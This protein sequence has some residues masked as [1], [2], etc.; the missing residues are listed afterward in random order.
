MLALSLRDQ[1]THLHVLADLGDDGGAGF[2]D[3]FAGRQLGVLQRFG[4]GGAGGQC[5]LGDGIGE[6]EEVVVL[7]HEVGLGI[8]LDQHGLAA[9]LRHHDAAFGGD[10][11]GLLVGLGQAGLAQP[12]GGGVDVAVVLGERLLA[13]HHAGAGALAQF[14]DQGSRNFSHGGYLGIL[15][16][17]WERRQSRLRHPPESHRD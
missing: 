7:G 5:G 13:L 14:L 8:D 10:A 4:I 16:V 15:G 3:G 1:A 9:V 11:A 6:G 2:L 17:L 12:L